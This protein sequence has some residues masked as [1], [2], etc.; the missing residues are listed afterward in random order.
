MINDNPEMT[1]EQMKMSLSATEKVLQ[2][3]I[4][5]PLT[6][7]M[8]AFLGLIYSLIVGAIVKRERPVSFN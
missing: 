6:I 3:E 7:V 1:E 2:P 5:F 8:Y 4:S